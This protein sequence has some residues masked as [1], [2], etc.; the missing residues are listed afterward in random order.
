MQFLIAELCIDATKKDVP[1]VAFVFHRNKP[2]FE[3]I[4]RVTTKRDHFE[5][6][7]L[8][9]DTRCEEGEVCLFAAMFTHLEVR[10]PCKIVKLIEQ[11]QGESSADATWKKQEVT[12][13]FK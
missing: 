13:S 8:V 7:I 12:P 5:A 1:E 10:Q 4:S 2:P 3:E 6:G 11:K 9:A